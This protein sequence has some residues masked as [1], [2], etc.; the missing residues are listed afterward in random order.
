MHVDLTKKEMVAGP[1]YW[2]LTAVHVKFGAH[3]K[4]EEKWQVLKG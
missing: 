1:M 4:E 3:K 2:W